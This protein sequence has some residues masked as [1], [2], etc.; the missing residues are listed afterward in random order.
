LKEGLIIKHIACYS[1]GEASGLVAIELVRKFGKENVILLNHDITIR[2][3]HYDIKRFKQELADYLG[4]PITFANME[5]WETKDQFDVCMDAKAF[6]VGVHPLCTNRIKTAPFHKW[7]E[8]EYP[9]DKETGKRED[10]ILYYGFEAKETERMKRRTMILGNKGY[11]TDYPLATWKRTIFSTTEIG[12]EPPNTYD[13][14]KHANCTGCLRAGRQHWYVVYCLKPEVFTKA[15]YA[16]S[17]IGHSILKGIYMHELEPKFEAMKQL[18]IK[19]DEKTQAA[20][21][22][23]QAK[24]LLGSQDQEVGGCDMQLDLFDSINI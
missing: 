18:G 9:V 14:W 12:I 17:V 22:W 10:I 6:K 1:G 8:V 4:I 11:M 16:E 5:N 23:S 7:L 20:T 13:I 19:A 24:K 15:K 2:S 21:F 3:E